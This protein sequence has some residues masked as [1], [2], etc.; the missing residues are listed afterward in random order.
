[1]NRRDFFKKATKRLLPIIGIVTGVAIF[2]AE[3]SSMPL[4]T[5]CKGQCSSTCFSSCNSSC[6]YLCDVG[7]GGCGHSCH[8]T[9]DGGTK[10]KVD[11]LVTKV[12]TLRIK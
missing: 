11:S 4:A 5:D 6:K 7:C 3:A 9:C 2:N 10:A 8:N 1:M 12:D